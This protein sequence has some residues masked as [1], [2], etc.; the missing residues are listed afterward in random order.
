[1]RTGTGRYHRLRDARIGFR[2]AAALEEEGRIEEA[3]AVYDRIV[4]SLDGDDGLPA[5]GRTAEALF[6]KS[7]ALF[8]LGEAGA[9]LALVDEVV[10]RFAADGLPVR[11][12]VMHMLFTT[13]CVLRLAHPDRTESALALCALAMRLF[14]EETDVCIRDR[15]LSLL[16]DQGRIL[17]SLGLKA[18]GRALADD[19]RRRYEAD[20]SWGPRALRVAEAMAGRFATASAPQLPPDGSDG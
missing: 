7:Q 1:M 15:L 5:R 20:P 18:E 12:R 2:R 14:G 9:A 6:L 3:L 16:V 19:I 13:V 4:A 17:E 10:A 11:R 8:D